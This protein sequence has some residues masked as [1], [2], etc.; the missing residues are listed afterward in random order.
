MIFYI[1]EIACYLNCLE[2]T[3][4]SVTCLEISQTCFLFF[5]NFVTAYG[6]SIYFNQLIKNFCFLKESSTA[7]TCRNSQLSMDS[8]VGLDNMSNLSEPIDDVLVSPSDN[9]GL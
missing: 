9:I 6:F 3:S 2:L 1:E 4:L 5:V 8:E 7:T